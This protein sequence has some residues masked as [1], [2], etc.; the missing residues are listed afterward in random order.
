MINSI[1]RTN[2]RRDLLIKTHQDLAKVLSRLWRMYWREYNTPA[3][4]KLFQATEKVVE[5]MKILD[6][7]N[8]L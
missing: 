2:H 6:E 1:G 3:E 5:L 4:T 8:E 7:L